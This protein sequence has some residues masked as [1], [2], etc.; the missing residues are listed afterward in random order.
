MAAQMEY[1]CTL[2]PQPAELKSAHLAAPTATDE[3]EH[4]VVAERTKLLGLGLEVDPR[5][6]PFTQRLREPRPLCE[7]R[8]QAFEV[9]LPEIRAV[10]VN[11]FQRGFAVAQRARVQLDSLG[12]TGTKIVVIDG[13][14]DDGVV[15][16][17]GPA[18]NT[19]GCSF[20][21]SLSLA[22]TLLPSPLV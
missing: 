2:G 5:L 7:R 8:A 16:S 20:G 6:S 3:H 10:L 12:A 4:P 13:F 21:L 22:E 19:V 17:V 1:C 18:G 9:A 11:R 15:E 14:A